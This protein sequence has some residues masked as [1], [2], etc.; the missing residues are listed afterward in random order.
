MTNVC[1]TSTNFCRSVARRRVSHISNAQ[2]LRKKGHTSTSVDM[3]P[4]YLKSL[5][6]TNVCHT[7]TNFC[8]SVARRSVSRISNS[9][10]RKTR[11][12]VELPPVTASLENGML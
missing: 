5:N 4:V 8:R 12:S 7:S 9:H 11:I 2:K 1:H 6:M 10:R 3:L